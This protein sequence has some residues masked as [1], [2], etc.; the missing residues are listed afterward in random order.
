MMLRRLKSGLALVCLGLLVAWTI[1]SPLGLASDETINIAV[2]TDPDSFDPAFSVAAATAEIAFNI[3][4]GLVKSTPDG[5]VAPALAKGWEIDESLTEYTFFLREAFF[6]NGDRVTTDDV[7]NAI[8]RARDPN[9]SQRA[10]RYQAITNVYGDGDR[11]KII[12]SKPYAPLLYELTELSAAVYPKDADG[13]G[14]NPIGTGP[15]QFVDWRPNQYVQLTRF[16]RHWSMEKPYFK[17]V[18]FRI[19]PDANSAVLS[20]KTGLIDLIPRLEP[21]FLHQVESD[22]KLKIEASPMNLV[23]LLAI[24]N[25]HPILADI[26]VRQAIAAAIDRD[27]II[28]GAAWDQGDKIF[29]GL[30]PAMPTFH[31]DQL[32]ELVPYDPERA[33]QL[34]KEAGYSNLKLTV[35]LPAAYPLH[36]QTGEIIVD[37]LSRVGI[38]VTIR[39][40]EWGTWLERVYNQR[41]YELTVTGLTGK[42]DPHTILSRYVSSEPKNFT[43]F[44]NQDFDELI[45]QG[46]I[47]SA[48]ERR[49]IYK[50]A[51]E[52]LAQDVAGVFIMDPR[53]L[54]V[55]KVEI[56]GWRN[57][58]VYVIDVSSL[59][60]QK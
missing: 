46:I 29:S 33:K 1:F 17:N 16:E 10:S 27:E 21:D 22:N 43:N 5:Q 23:Q 49:D 41:D 26:R 38:D 2:P 36:V 42:L 30:S 14:N 24:N 47:A 50:N 52:I 4:E 54:T 32:E 15:Y 40:I 6:H 53:Q 56:N 45:E 44:D 8:N 25:K 39:I 18:N 11:V 59:Y 12:L 19:M 55:S 60:N 31:H 37:Q 3:Y 9:V 13:L 48:E 28:F 20:L 7:V 57:Y 58:P 34:L 35:D 51:Q